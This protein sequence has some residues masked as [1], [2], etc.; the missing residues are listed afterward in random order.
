MAG[1]VLKT[2]KR[3]TS[4]S[5]TV[6]RSAVSGAFV[7]SLAKSNNR[8]SSTKTAKVAKRA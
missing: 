2:A 5:R 7:K 1:I 4:R 3:E 8:S 6:V